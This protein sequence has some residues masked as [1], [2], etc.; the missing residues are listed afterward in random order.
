MSKNY[1]GLTEDSTSSVLTETIKQDNKT[2]RQM[3]KLYESNKSSDYTEKME[4]LYK[5]F[6]YSDNS[7]HNWTYPYFSVLYGSPI[8]ESASESQKRA[9]NHLYWVCFYN[10]VMG[11]E[12]TTMVCNQICC[13]AF[14]P[15]GG[16]EVVCHELDIET[17]QERVHVEAFR[18]I[19]R[20]TELSLFGKTIF[21]R[22][23]PD[24]VDGSVIKPQKRSRSLID[25]LPVQFL[26][27]RM[28]TS[29]FLATQYFTARGLRNIQAKVKEY[30][31]SLY[32]RERSK[33]D[34]FVCA[35]TL[36]SHNHCF[37]EG[38]HTTTS[39][40]ISHELR[41]EFDKPNSLDI[42][43]ANEMIRGVQY[44]FNALSCAVPGIF[45]DDA[46]YMPLV[47]E[48]LQSPLFNLSTQEALLLMEKSFCQEHEGFHVAAKYH[49]RAFTQNLEFVA[50]LDYLYP[51]NR[52]LRVVASTSIDE[53][54]KNNIS[55]FQRF[56]KSF[57]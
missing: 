26:F 10:Y 50:G 27:A 32:G 12:I 36:V 6:N 51:V 22:P 24:Y 42:F 11:G 7:E 46:Q 54:I 3:E 33:R 40:F 48:M 29:P 19:G 16:Y 41:K 30:Q 25:R 9:L 55:A 44:S 45:S 38:F 17:S 18:H 8:Y 53:A 23:M 4:E 57:N 52:E 37:D 56:S 20:M 21:E 15:L 34:E 31:H 28:G 47:Y 39:K 14:Y 5:S 1:A 13:G 43:L 49:H 35:P 2:L